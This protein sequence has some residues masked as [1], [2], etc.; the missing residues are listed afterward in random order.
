MFDVFD[1]FDLDFSG[2]VDLGEMKQLY[3]LGGGD[4]FDKGGADGWLDDAIF[5]HEHVFG[6]APSFDVLPEML[7]EVLP[8]QTVHEQPV[9]EPPD[10][11]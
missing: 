6:S 7:P 4:C 10:P 2:L 9:P 8:E 11:A 3:T 5:M 1:R